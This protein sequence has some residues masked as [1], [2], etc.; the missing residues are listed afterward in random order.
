MWQGFEAMNTVVVADIDENVDTKD[1]YHRLVLP[2]MSTA[3]YP[4]CLAPAIYSNFR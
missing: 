3:V 2:C 4:F 1:L